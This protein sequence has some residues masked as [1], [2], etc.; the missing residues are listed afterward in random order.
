MTEAPLVTIRLQ[1][2]LLAVVTGLCG[3][4]VLGLVGGGAYFLWEQATLW[5]LWAV[6]CLASAG[7]LAW[8][9]W[10]AIKANT[11]IFADRI[12]YRGGFRSREIRRGDIRGFRVNNGFVRIY[13]RDPGAKPILLRDSELENEQIAQWFEG[14]VDLDAVERA[15]AERAL[16]ADESFGRDVAE[17]RARLKRLNRVAVV[18]NGAAWAIGAWAWL[19]PQPYI[20]A[21]TAAASLPLVALLACF[22]SGRRFAVAIDTDRSDARPSLG[23]MPMVAG[24]ALAIRALLDFNIL[25]WQ[26]TLLAATGIAFCLT[27]ALVLADRKLLSKRWQVVAAALIAFAYGCGVFI[28]ADVEMDTA[29]VQLYPTVVRDRHVSSG[30]VARYEVSVDPWGPV[31]EA[32]TVY[33]TR[34]FYEALNTGDRVC[35]YMWPG[36]FGVRWYEAGRC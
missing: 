21:V 6:L 13:S 8:V 2:L 10:M 29:P 28:E 30:K 32:S 16:E 23:T 19:K 34:N 14:L 26:R 17:R 15:E 9:L 1:G 33:V 27:T 24:A 4:V 18:L 31:R 35:I 5:S 25:D 12:V 22:V 7:G 11:Q 20:W 36:R 3:L